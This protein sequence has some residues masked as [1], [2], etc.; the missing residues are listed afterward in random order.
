VIIKIHS[1]GHS[2]KGLAQYLTHDPKAQTAE[3]VAWTYTLNCAHDDVLSAVHEMY[4]TCLHAQL[5]KEEAGVRAGG[6][7]LEK[8]V[9]HISLSW[10]PGQEPSREQMIEATESFLRHMGWDEHQALLVAHHDKE[11]RHAHVMLNTVHP[12]TGLK[13]DDSFERRRAQAW[14]LEYEREHGEVLCKERLKEP[15]E[16]EVSP[17]RNSWLALKESER[18][19]QQAE[20]KR[21]SYDPDHLGREDNHAVSEGEEW[22][23]LKTHQRQEREAFFA[24]GKT[25]FTELRK[26]IYREVREEFREE[27]GNYYA[28]KREGLDGDQ[29]AAIRADILERQKAMLDE[30][31]NEACVALREQRDG[32]YAALLI[33]QKEARHDLAERQEQGLTSPHL[34]DLAHGRPGPEL[35]RD[36]RAPG[37]SRTGQEHGF[38]LAAQEACAPTARERDAGEN[39]FV[40]ATPGITSAE[41][42]R[43]RDG[44]DAVGDLGMGAIGALATIGER[45]FDGFFGGAAPR[46]PAQQ[47]ERP[48]PEPELP[49]DNALARATEAAQRNAEQQQDHDK[50]NRA[51]WDERERS[52]ER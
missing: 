3:R 27:W 24:G 35:V 4:T 1:S 50:R 25:A 13:L 6:R 15:G 40:E 14:G 12:D 32:E 11:H 8:P 44:A 42:P 38:Q 46:G 19:H 16:R 39:S 9:K 30:R 18:Q 48:A 22:K 51:Y 52:R 43:V 10:E 7:K 5:L 17:D 20:E 23:L 45:F 2:F 34:L 37:T 49:R 29:L 28:A 21:R 26:E 31:R 36:S 41:N 47:P 33:S